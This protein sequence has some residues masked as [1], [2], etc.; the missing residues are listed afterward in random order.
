[1]LPGRSGAA[2]SG[3]DKNPAGVT[4]E[5]ISQEETGWGGSED[6]LLAALLAANTDATHSSYTHALPPTTERTGEEDLS[7]DSAGWK[8]RVKVGLKATFTFTLAP[9]C[10]SSPPG[11][12]QSSIF[13]RFNVQCWFNEL[14]RHNKSTP[15]NMTQPL[16]DAADNKNRAERSLK[17]FRNSA[18]SLKCVHTHTHRHTFII[19]V[20]L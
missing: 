10:S 2:G 7:V 13:Y 16:R 20:G 9:A 6:V 3:N 17:S 11:G 8:K 19:L 14:G 1:M 18:C 4:P 15:R 5:P 12:L